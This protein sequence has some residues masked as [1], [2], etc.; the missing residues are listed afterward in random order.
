MKK[1]LIFLMFI[2][3]G[4][5]SYSQN[6][7]HVWSGKFGNEIYL[8]SAS[9]VDQSGNSFVLSFFSGTYDF[10][11]GPGIF[12]MTS[13]TP[14]PGSDIAICKIDVNGD[15]IWAKQI[16]GN[17]PIG[18]APYT[19][20]VDSSGDLFIS[21]YFN[22]NVDFDPSPGMNILTSIFDACFLIKMD[23]NGNLIWAN[24]I[25]ESNGTSAEFGLSVKIDNNN[26]VVL[27]GTFQGS[28]DFD[29][30]VGTSILTTFENNDESF[31]AKYD[32]NGNFIWAKAFVNTQTSSQN[33]VTSFSVDNIGNIYC[34]G[35]F[36]GGVD[37]DPGAGLNNLI[38]TNSQRD[39][40]FV[41]L[42]QNGA[43]VWSQAI[44]SV[45]EDVA[46]SVK[47][48]SLG[49][50]CVVGRFQNTV[51]FNP[52]GAGNSLSSNGN[53]DIFIANYNSSGIL[54]WALNVGGSL[55]DV[56]NDLDIDPFDNIYV[57][58][59]FQNVV[60]FDPGLGNEILSS[61]NFGSI[62]VLKIDPT[63][64]FLFAES[65]DATST[66][67]ILSART[68][69]LHNGYLHICG[70]FNGSLELES[71]NCI[72]ELSSSVNSLFIAKY[73][74]TSI[75]DP[76]IS[77][78]TPLTC[79]QNAVLESSS[80]S[81]NL[82]STG[83]TNTS[84]SVINGDYQ[85]TVEDGFGCKLTDCI[86]IDP[87]DLN[88]SVSVDQPCTWD[89][90]AIYT[91][92]SGGSPPYTYQ[93]NYPGQTSPNL[94]GVPPGDYS[95]TVTDAIGCSVTANATLTPQLTDSDFDYPYGYTV[96]NS[97]PNQFNDGGNGI[98]SIRGTLII[99]EGVNIDLNGL[100][101]EFARDLEYD[102]PDLG[103]THSGIIIEP[104]AKLKATNCIFKGVNQCDAMWQGIQ[105]WG[106]QPNLLQHSKRGKPP[107]VIASLV[108][109][110]EAELSNCVV[111][112]A[113]IGVACHRVN[114]PLT[115]T[116]IDYGRG[117]LKARGTDFIN[118]RVGVSFRGLTIIPNNST[119]YDC[120]FICNAPLIHPYKYDGE[121]TDVFVRLTRVKNPL[122]TANNFTGNTAFSI[123][124]RGTGILSFDASYIVESA[125]TGFVTPFTPK[126]P[127]IFTDMSKGIDIYA[128]GGAQSVVTITD[129]RFNNVYQGI[130]GGGNN[131]D[132]ISY[133]RFN[134]PAGDPLFNSWAMFLQTSSGFL[135]SQNT[136]NTVGTNA[137]TFG[138]IGSDVT[139]TMGEIYKN[140]FNGSYQSGTQ[141]EGDVNDQLQID[142]NTYN[143]TNTYDWTVLT[144]TLADQ[145]VCGTN[146]E[147]AVTNQFGTCV[148]ADESQI[149]SISSFFYNTTN[150]A[151]PVC[152]STP[153]VNLISCGFSPSNLSQVCPQHPDISC[154]NCIGN[155]SMIVNT[156]PGLKRDRLKGQYVR[157]L[158]Q[159]G[160]FE[161]LHTF[162]QDEGEN[163]DRRI[164]ISTYVQEGKFTEARI[165]LNNFNPSGQSENDFYDLFDVLVGIG[166]SGRILDQVSPIEKQV[167]A[168]IANGTTEVRIVAQAVLSEIDEIQVV[169]FPQQVPQNHAPV[170]MNNDDTTTP[171]EGN[172]QPSFNL[173][174]NPT[175]GQVNLEI[176]SAQP[177]FVQLY[178]ETGRLITNSNVNSGT[179]TL[180]Y[181][182]VERG[183]YFVVINFSETS[184]E[185]VRLII[186]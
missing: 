29:P 5:S 19:I 131:F 20:D 77:V 145:G 82:W 125:Q 106:D 32:N 169:R 89:E 107:V 87:Y 26:N 141:A 35:Y 108:D 98:I 30:G 52:L 73:C 92:V 121:G 86:T 149:F 120:N 128:K 55:D 186:E 43:W 184:I 81:N 112:D 83:S 74:E 42:D 147:E 37:F 126:T 75:S 33:R 48:N 21:G 68:I 146:G 51:D 9:I 41:K 178:D 102:I 65:F 124:K 69:N 99:Q 56:A 8:E 115:N 174:P 45:G 116:P 173:Y 152:Y 179:N 80:P 176:D 53:Y 66:T 118:N 166:E 15:L 164:M 135:V 7:G 113:E 150:F 96:T 38:S 165:E 12:N 94:E 58:G 18:Q 67:G 134:T 10:D 57:T 2:M 111:R 24:K 136:M 104:G 156:P 62:Y 148:T 177:V 185:T 139:L 95:V 101:F 181:S 130:T 160:D 64:N 170:W 100:T 1:M 155:S 34:L 76:I 140:N 11:P 16:T 36:H 168:D 138:V 123:T 129:N 182:W 78:T 91:T 79:D 14:S 161:T 46:M 133:N 154:P 162:L 127:N 3:L 163:D 39:I 153:E 85:L 28:N 50:L 88:V 47:M 105:I 31:I 159:A 59:H 22:G 90:G 109:N 71:G 70:L 142:C 49:E 61:P 117:L 122:I 157:A 97:N 103:M 151:N 40:Y 60:D 171:I 143:G 114:Y 13:Q 17:S 72:T 175:M 119:V 137:Y 158:A 4:M 93:W 167:I 44:G 144:P 23:A 180:D 110:G 172:S 25:T 183:V 54:Q 27:G 6:L 132:E 84:I 63:G